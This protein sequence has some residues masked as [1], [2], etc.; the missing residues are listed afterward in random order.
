MTLIGTTPSG[1]FANWSFPKGAG[2]ERNAIWGQEAMSEA[3]APWQA[4]Q[5]FGASSLSLATR[6]KES[7][8]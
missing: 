7:P 8:W 5:L 1:T 2:C 4:A 6:A 3:A